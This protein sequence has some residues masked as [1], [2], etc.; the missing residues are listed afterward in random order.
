MWLARLDLLAF[1]RFTDVRLH[2]D[3]GLHIVYGPNE[4]GKTTTLRAIRQLMFGFDERTQAEHLIN[5]AAH[6]QV[7]DELWEEARALHLA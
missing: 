7:R 2:F 3:R 6:P 5:Q 4:A 1:G